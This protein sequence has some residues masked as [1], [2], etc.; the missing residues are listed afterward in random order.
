MW[1]IISAALRIRHIPSAPCVHPITPKLTPL[2]P[3]FVAPLLPLMFGYVTLVV[4][5][6][7]FNQPSVALAVFS[8]WS[9]LLSL[10][11]DPWS[12]VWSLCH[13]QT[14]ADLFGSFSCQCIWMAAYYQARW[15]SVRDPFDHFA[16]NMHHLPGVLCLLKGRFRKKKLPVFFSLWIMRKINSRGFS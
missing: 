3:A 9:L 2:T 14:I 15:I 12:C 13:Q 8:Q 10:S 11:L 4:P 7:R 1:V 16:L 6:F 5:L